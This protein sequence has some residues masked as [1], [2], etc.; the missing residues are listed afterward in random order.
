MDG[1][2]GVIVGNDASCEDRVAF[3]NVPA[4]ELVWF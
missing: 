4:L 1:G 3:D 2:V